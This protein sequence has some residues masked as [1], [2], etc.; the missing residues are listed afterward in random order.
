MP[1]DTKIARRRELIAILRDLPSDHRWDFENVGGPL[2]GGTFG[3]AFAIMHRLWPTESIGDLSFIGLS[4]SDNT[5]RIFGLG[6]TDCP[7]G[8]YS[9]FYGCLASE[10][11]PEMVAD[12]L[13]VS[14]PSGWKETIKI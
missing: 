11:T 14:D 7:N 3:C 5:R 1:D 12:A 9:E 6:L 8:M 13:D 10:V 4:L 2:F